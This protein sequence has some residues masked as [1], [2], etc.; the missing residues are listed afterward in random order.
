VGPFFIRLLAKLK[1]AITLDCDIQATY[2]QVRLS[3]KEK[4]AIKLVV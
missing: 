3:Y 1:E 4:I 2:F